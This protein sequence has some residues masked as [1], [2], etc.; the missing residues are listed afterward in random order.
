MP[1]GIVQVMN[2]TSR[3]VHYHNLQTGHKIDIIPKTDQYENNDW[4]PSSNFHD[5][6]VPYTSTS[7][8]EVK[9]D[10]G[11]VVDISDHNWKFHMV[12]PVDGTSE[13]EEAEYGSLTNG[14]KYIL[15]LDEVD[16]GRVKRCAFSF[17]QYEGKY[18]VTAGYIAAQLIQHA[19]PV[20]A[21]VLMAI[22]L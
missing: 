14:G 2:N 12:G 4:I 17:L 6:T 5:D 10:D 21:L 20:V 8:I 1:V 11:P 13:R 16:D 3:T 22:F 19:A 9:L 15:R 7:H 18:K